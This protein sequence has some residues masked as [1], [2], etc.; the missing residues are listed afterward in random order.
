M[1]RPP[2]QSP[3]RTFEG[4]Q[5]CS[6]KALLAF[7]VNPRAACVALVMAQHAVSKDGKY[8]SSYHGDEANSYVLSRGQLPE[9]PGRLPELRLQLP[10]EQQQRVA[11]VR[12]LR[13]VVGAT[14]KQCRSC[15]CSP[16][17]NNGSV[18]S[19]CCGPSSVRRRRCGRNGS[20]NSQNGSVSCACFGASD[21]QTQRSP[22]GVT[23]EGAIGVGSGC[24]GGRPEPLHGV[25]APPDV[26]CRRTL[27][28]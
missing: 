25:R 27:L 22:P 6:L 14:T 4:G 16:S 10:A 5:G 8:R 15:N 20:W 7:S 28:L 19:A 1:R 3:I 11:V 13:R 2:R 17:A 21:A 26:A 12:V 23:I 24:P 9:P 18:S